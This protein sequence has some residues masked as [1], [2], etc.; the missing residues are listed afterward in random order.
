[1]DFAYNVAAK[2]EVIE[3]ARHIEQC[4]SG[5]DERQQ[6]VAQN[7]GHPWSPELR[8]DLL[9]DSHKPGDHERLGAR[10]GY[11]EWVE[12]ESR[13]RIGQIEV[14]Q[15]RF[16]FLRH[17]AHQFFEN[18]IGKLVDAGVDVHFATESLI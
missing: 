8:P 15:I 1:L 2:V 18:D 17:G 3:Q 16:S 9:E 5:H 14:D 4:R 12:S 13:C 7:V 11:F 10:L 6:H